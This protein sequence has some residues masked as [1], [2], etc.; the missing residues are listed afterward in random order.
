MAYLWE[1]CV[2]WVSG[3]HLDTLLVI[4]LP[5]IL[6]GSLVDRLDFINPYSENGL[7]V[8]RYFNVIATL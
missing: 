2:K 7:S 4:S 8:Q 5:I 3:F 1:C 6:K